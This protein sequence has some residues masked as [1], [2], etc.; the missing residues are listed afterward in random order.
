M[1]DPAPPPSKPLRYL[2]ERHR[3]KTMDYPLQA[4]QRSLELQG[5]RG[6]FNDADPARLVGRVLGKL[7]LLRNF[8]RLSRAAY[9]APIMQVSEYR[10]FP[11]CYWAET[12]VYVFDC[13]PSAYDRWEA[14]FRRQRMRI[15]FV[16]AR[17]SAERMRQ[18]VPGLEAIWMPEGIELAR[19]KP[20]KPLRERTIDVLE[21]GRRMPAYHEKIRDHCA[22][23]GY[24]HKYEATRGQWVFATEEEFYRGLS[25]SK[26]SICFP[27]SMTHPDRAG[28]VETM[29]LR[30]L[31]SIACRS[32]V[33]GHCPA[34]LRDLFG[35]DPVIAA[36]ATD[37]AAQLDHILT[38]LGDYEDSLDRN[39][40]RL[41]EVGTWDVRVAQMLQILRERGYVP[42]GSPLG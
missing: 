32:I 18:R 28:D 36:D 6:K 3:G 15:T 39:L 19:Y 37:P 34:E 10:L 38:N 40:T 17:Q 13:W 9:F 42:E 1:A 20:D 33:V 30:Y 27:S 24:V 16:S 4:I 14:F 29:T 12:L 35:F 23:R 21:M 22:A 25:D 5:V 8:A 41:R 26:I 31:E 7:K 11:Q 2:A